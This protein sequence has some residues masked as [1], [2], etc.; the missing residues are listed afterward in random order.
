MV[1]GEKNHLLHLSGPQGT[2]SPQGRAWFLSGEDK[3]G[4]IRKEGEEFLLWLS[5]LRTQLVSTRMQ[6]RSLTLL[7]G[8]RIQHCRE[9]WHRSQMW[10]G[11]GIAAAVA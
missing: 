11:S 9:L 3:Q 6:V 1:V 8:L 10:L 2:Q 4:H 7:S 5:G